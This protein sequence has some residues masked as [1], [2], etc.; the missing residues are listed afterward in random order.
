MIPFLDPIGDA[1]KWLLNGIGGSV[2][3]VYG[4]LIRT[5][6]LTKRPPFTYHEY[7]NGP[8]QPEDVIFDTMGHRFNNILLGLL[9]FVIILGIL[10]R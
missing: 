2:R 9:T 10:T 5:L 6:R 4:T 7:L 3:Y 1:F 8:N